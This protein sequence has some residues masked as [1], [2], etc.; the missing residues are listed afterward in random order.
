MSKKKRKKLN[1]PL[2]SKTDTKSFVKWVVNPILNSLSK[3]DYYNTQ[4]NPQMGSN[5]TGAEKAR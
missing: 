4:S 1:K 5:H 2:P 3:N